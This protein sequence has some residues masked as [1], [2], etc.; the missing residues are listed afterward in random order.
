M[1]EAISAKDARIGEL[2]TSLKEIQSNSE[3]L[4]L[5]L[6][7]AGALQ[8]KFDFSKAASR[9]EEALKEEDGV[10]KSTENVLKPSALP[11]STRLD[12]L[13]S[14]VT[15][16]SSAVSSRFTPTIGNHALLGSSG[17]DSLSSAF[18]PMSRPRQCFV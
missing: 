11:V 16:Q 2:S 6:E 10:K 1:K 17:N 8:E 7:K 15:S 9:E 5:Q 14:L 18:R 13:S 12:A 4:Q 3:K